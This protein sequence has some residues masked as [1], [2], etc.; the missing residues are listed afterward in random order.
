MIALSAPTFDPSG[1]VRL[2]PLPTSD[3]DSIRRRVTR[4]RTLDAVNGPG[5]VVN[6]GG[7]VHGDRTFTV[8]FRPRSAAEY[9][10]VA[11]MVRLYPRIIVSARGGVFRA[12]ASD[13]SL[14]NGEAAMTLLV[15]ERME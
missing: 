7:F 1:H 12:A 9:E 10:R 11:R 13:L 6:D 5:V 2:H 4:R 15:I 3:L 8:R 14:S